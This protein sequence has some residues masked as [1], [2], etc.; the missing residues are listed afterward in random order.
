MRPFAWM[1]FL[2]ALTTVSPLAAQTSSSITVVDGQTLVLDGRTYQLAGITAPRMGEQC[3]VRS[4]R[5]DCGLIARAQ[6]LDLT[7]GAAIECR[8]ASSGAG[9]VPRARCLSNGYDISRGMVYTGWARAVGDRYRE[10]EIEARGARR[11][12]WNSGPDEDPDTR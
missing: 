4:Q 3:T 7:A 2:A 12:M 6:L 10:L 11:G 8:V 9:E 1:F 5:R